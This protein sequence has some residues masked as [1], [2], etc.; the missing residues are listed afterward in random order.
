MTF[1]LK[2][3]I[4]LSNL[5]VAE[6]LWHTA[7]LNA[8]VRPPNVCDTG[9][10]LKEWCDNQVFSVKMGLF[11]PLHSFNDTENESADS[12]SLSNL[13]AKGPVKIQIGSPS[14]TTLSVY[15]DL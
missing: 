13:I 14:E 15:Q 6:N 9:T 1:R 7:S 4:S 8:N 10:L 11:L 2:P 12:V 3:N 5:I